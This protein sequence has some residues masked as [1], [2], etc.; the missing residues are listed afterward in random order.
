MLVSRMRNLAN[1]FVHN[2]LF[3]IAL[4]YIVLVVIASVFNVDFFHLDCPS[5]ICLF[6][7]GGGILVLFIL[8]RSKKLWKIGLI[9]FVSIV[10]L[11]WRVSLVNI[12]YDAELD[13][14]I[15]RYDGGSDIIGIIAGEPKYSSSSVLLPMRICSD[16]DDVMSCFESEYMVSVRTNRYPRKK[17]GQICKIDGG[18]NRVENFTDDFDYERY[19]RMNGVVWR[20][21]RAVVD[22][23]DVEMTRYINAGIRP[24][25]L[26]VRSVLYAIREYLTSPVERAFL[27][28]YASLLIGMV[29]GCDRIFSDEFTHS[30]RVSGTMHIIAAS[31]YNITLVER[32]VDL[33][34]FFMPKKIRKV[35]SAIGVLSFC[36]VAGMGASVMRAAIMSVIRNVAKIIGVPSQKHTV[37]AYTAFVMLLANPL[38]IYSAG[39]LLSMSA[40]LFLTYLS[41]VLIMRVERG[42]LNKLAVRA[43]SKIGSWFHALYVYIVGEIVTSVTALLATAPIFIIIFKQLSLIGLMSNLFITPLVDYVIFGG[44]FYILTKSHLLAYYTTGLLKFVAKVITYF[45]GLEWGGVSL[46]KSPYINFI[47]TVWIGALLYYTY[48]ERIWYMREMS[49][50]QSRR[51]KFSTRMKPYYEDG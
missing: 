16:R 25:F 13:R 12:S 45:G 5:G 44:I 49:K 20:I 51:F 2:E 36:M 23:D 8:R 37:I 35:V 34:F 28:P 50:L 29:F 27:E 14:Y 26:Y 39:F 22:C 3:S 18:I 46:E 47:V 32:A 31:G 19:M 33:L 21:D 6:L 48:V 30:L 38:I 43:T 40:T 24:V 41:P 1:F 9:L 15:D 42:C 4:L 11:V 10:L 7:I 17:I